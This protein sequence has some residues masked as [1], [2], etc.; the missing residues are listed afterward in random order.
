MNKVELLCVKADEHAERL[1]VYTL[2]DYSLSLFLERE[3]GVLGGGQTDMVRFI[4]QC[5]LLLLF[6]RQ[7]LGVQI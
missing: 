6:T 7:T 3:P 5:A 1:I 4:G 2:L